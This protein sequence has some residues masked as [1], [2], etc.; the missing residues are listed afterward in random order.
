MKECPI[1]GA[2]AFDDA[3]ICYGCLYRFSQG[4]AEQGDA[5]DG[6]LDDFV[7]GKED[8]AATWLA[9]ES[10]SKAAD[11]FE[12]EP[13]K[14]LA[15]AMA[16]AIAGGAGNMPALRI[17]LTPPEDLASGASWQCAV[18]FASA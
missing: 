18:Q 11:G 3:R 16:E 5:M 13:T 7:G 6:R 15:S 2:R 10:M 4:E 8:S 1:C 12:L 9:D 14:T 17:T